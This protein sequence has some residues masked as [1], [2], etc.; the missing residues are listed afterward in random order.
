MKLTTTKLTILPIGLFLFGLC[1]IPTQTFAASSKLSCELTL[2]TPEGRTTV[3]DDAKVYLKRGDEIKIAWESSNAKQASLGAA[4]ISLDGS[5]TSSPTKHTTY[6]YTFQNGSKKVECAVDVVVVD[7][8]FNDL[9]FSEKTSK[10]TISGVVNGATTVQ[11]FIYKEG[12]SKPVFTSKVLKVK[13]GK[14][15]T[16]VTKALKP[17]EYTAVLKGDKKTELNT[18]ATGTLSIGKSNDTKSKTTFYTELV[19]LLAGGVAKSGSAVPISYLQ[20]LNIGKTDGTV[21]GFTVK[22]NGTL[23]ANAIVG[24]IVSDS[25]SN[26]VT[27]AGSPAQPIRFVGTSATIPVDITMQSGEMRLFTLKAILSPLLGTNFGKTI[28]LDVADVVTN[29]TDKGVFPIRGAT[30]TLGF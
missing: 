9:S 5:A 21:K 30:W 29:A 24:F 13:K 4:K 7:G 6:N 26:A 3:T 1:I 11:L 27:I 20:I 18:I 25:T 17:G 22:Q 15:S 23:P 12:I 10:P 14:W 8:I 19:P 28:K 16:R 2:T